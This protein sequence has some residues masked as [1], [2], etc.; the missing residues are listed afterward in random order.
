MA[1]ALIYGLVARGTGTAASDIDLLVVASELTLEELYSALALVKGVLVRRI[2]PTLYTPA[3]YETRKAADNGV[4]AQVLAG[5][6]VML[7]ERD[8]GPSAAR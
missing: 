6:H 2:N 5:E 4:L 1:L 3:E 7:I 8:G